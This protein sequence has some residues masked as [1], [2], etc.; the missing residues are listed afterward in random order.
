MTHAANLSESRHLLPWSMLHPHG[1]PA[2]IL[3]PEGASPSG[4]PR[5][6]QSVDRLAEAASWA[7]AGWLT[8]LPGVG[9]C[10]GSDGLYRGVDDAEHDLRTLVAQLRSLPD[11][12]SVELLGTGS[13]GQLALLLA[14]RGLEVDRVVAVAPESPSTL[15]HLP[16]E[17][18]A[19]SSVAQQAS[20]LPASVVV[21]EPGPELLEALEAANRQ[22]SIASQAPEREVL[23]EAL[24]T[25]H[26]ALPDPAE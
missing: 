22:S 21:F 16:E 6:C 11:T 15:Q 5:E 13:G 4:L 20:E 8:V 17:L 23:E 12:A 10:D 25:S 18:R 2:L 1:L 26:V 7:A 9:G 14:L 3:L 24:K 19:G